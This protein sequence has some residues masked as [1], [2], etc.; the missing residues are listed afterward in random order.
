MSLK[1]PIVKLID[2]ESR[3]DEL[4]SNNNPFAIITMAHLK[5]KATIG[6]FAEREK[7]KWQL[8]RGLYDWG[9]TKQQIDELPHLTCLTALYANVED[10]VSAS[11]S[12]R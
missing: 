1:F 6:K 9:L 8:I 7:W 4:E 12:V 10:G 3:W 5:T 11:P 2:Y